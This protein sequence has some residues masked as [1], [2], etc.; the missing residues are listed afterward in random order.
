MKNDCS[1]PMGEL[2]F[3]A[4]QLVK[5]CSDACP[6]RSWDGDDLA[7]FLRY[8]DSTSRWG[9]LYCIVYLKGEKVRFSTSEL[10]SV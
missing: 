5:I 6:N 7:V 2:E 3:H 1:Y 9:R 8:H 4:G 10:R